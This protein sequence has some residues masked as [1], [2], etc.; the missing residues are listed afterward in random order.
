[1]QTLLR[2][3]EEIS[4][5]FGLKLSQGKCQQ[6]SVGTINDIKFKDETTVPRTELA[7]YFGALLHHKADPRKEILKRIKAP[8]KTRTYPKLILNTL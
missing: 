1:M 8:P 6:M 2:S 4:D 3:I 5:A 7:E